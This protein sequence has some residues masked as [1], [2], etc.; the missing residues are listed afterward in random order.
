[1]PEQ[2]PNPKQVRPLPVPRPALAPVDSRGSYAELH[3]KTNFSFL[4]GAS[5]PDELVSRASE[6]DYSALAVTDRNTLSGIVRAHVAA[7]AA[8][9]KFWSVQRSPPQMALQWRFS[10]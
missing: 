5:H 3:C 9:L 4:E 6:L 10:Q 1:M 2:P 8:G 7:K